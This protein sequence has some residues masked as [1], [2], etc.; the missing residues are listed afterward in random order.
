MSIEVQL[1][2]FKPV[3]KPNPFEGVVAQVI[4]ADSSD[5]AGKVSIPK[6]IALSTAQTKIREAA[7]DAGQRARIRSVD[8]ETR[9]VTFTL[10]ARKASDAEVSDDEATEAAEE[11]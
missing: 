7:K 11:G 6:E 9:V 4:E 2:E 3:R 8:E 10:H 1:T 5:I